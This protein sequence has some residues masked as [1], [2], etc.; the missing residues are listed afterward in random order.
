[1][2]VENATTNKIFPQEP[3][4]NQEVSEQE[5]GEQTTIDNKSENMKE[6]C[7]LQ[8][9]S[10]SVSDTE[11]STSI[12]RYFR[13][14]KYYPLGNRFQLTF[15]DKDVDCT[16]RKKLER[17]L[18]KRLKKIRRKFETLTGKEKLNMQCRKRKLQCT[19]PSC[20]F[21]DVKLEQHLRSKSHNLPQKRSALAQSFMS[22]KTKHICFSR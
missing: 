3:Q 14:D 2:N 5:N 6:K 15:I 20:K 12:F 8:N 10:E 4:S 21:E 19:S 16:K 1:M 11:T 18:E 13:F 7:K 9:S 17:I 22:Q